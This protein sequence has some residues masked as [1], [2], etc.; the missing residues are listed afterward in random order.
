MK[1]FPGSQY[2]NSSTF[3]MNTHVI[4]GTSGKFSAGEPYIKYT[5]GPSVNQGTVFVVNGNSGSREQGAPLNH[6]AFYFDDDGYGSF[7]MEVQGNRLDGKYLSSTGAVMDEFTILK[8]PYEIQTTVDVAICEGES[9]FAGG[10]DQTVTGTYYD[11]LHAASGPDTLVITHLTVHPETPAIERQTNTLSV[12]DVYA[13]YQWY[14]DNAELQGETSSS[15]QAVADGDY[16]VEVGDTH[17][18]NTFSD[19]LSVIVIGIRE[20]Q[21]IG[22]QF[23]PNPVTNEVLV[24]FSRAVPGRV[25]I[26]VYNAIGERVALAHSSSFNKDRQV[27]SMAHLQSGNYLIKVSGEHVDVNGWVVK[28]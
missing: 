21:A 28:Q 6:P 14:M 9:H 5:S 22:V 19:T 20:P 10:A 25:Q 3:N 11:T 17:G 26:D 8:M 18:C 7:M 4:N 24:T 27:I 1:G 12:P 23:F 2:P 15:L 16:F 13:S